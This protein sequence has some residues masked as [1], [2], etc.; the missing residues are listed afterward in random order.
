MT[1]PVARPR[2][3]YKDGK[4]LH[5]Y[6]YFLDPE[7]G[8]CYLRVP[9]WAPFRLQFYCNGHSWLAGQLQQAGIAYEPL[10]NTFR[11]LADPARAQALADAFPVERLHR[12]A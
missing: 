12:A 4:C 10:D 6:F 11:T 2:L 1:R 8:L 9:T 3:R 7:F 5:Y